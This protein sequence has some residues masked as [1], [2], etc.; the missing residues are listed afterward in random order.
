MSLQ[1]RGRVR[2]KRESWETRTCEIGGDNLGGNVDRGV[3]GLAGCSEGAEDL[4]K[5]TE[6]EAGGERGKPAEPWGPEESVPEDEANHSPRTGQL[7]CH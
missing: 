4:A 7:S 1:L 3:P 5:E 2:P 6:K